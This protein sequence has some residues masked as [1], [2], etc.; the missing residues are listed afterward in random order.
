[1]CVCECVCVCDVCVSMYV[2][3]CVCVRVRVCVCYVQVCTLY[4]SNC[5]VSCKQHLQFM[6]QT[7]LCHGAGFDDSH[8]FFHGEEVLQFPLGILGVG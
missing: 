1:M 7:F 5:V 6:L 2:C 4:V 3:V 8:S